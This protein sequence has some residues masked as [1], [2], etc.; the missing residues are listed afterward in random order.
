VT[1]ALT[2]LDAQSREIAAALKTLR[3]A[4]SPQDESPEDDAF[5]IL[6]T[7]C[8]IALRV[9]R[10][11]NPSKIRDEAR[12]VEIGARMRGASV[13]FREAR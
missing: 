10:K 13:E 8:A 3:D 2:I 1:R 9:M 7:F 4:Y 11:T 6:E 12:T 5:V